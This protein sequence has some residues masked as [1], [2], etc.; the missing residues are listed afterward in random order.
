MFGPIP[1]KDV[2]KS[3]GQNANTGAVVCMHVGSTAAIASRCCTYTT[4]HTCAL[5]CFLF[6]PFLFFGLGQVR[7]VRFNL[8]LDNLPPEKHDPVGTGTC[9]SRVSL[10]FRFLVP[11]GLPCSLWLYISWKHPETS[12]CMDV[13]YEDVGRASSLISSRCQPGNFETLVCVGHDA[14]YT[15]LIEG[16]YVYPQLH[17]TESLMTCKA[18]R[19][20]SI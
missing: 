17:V 9:L 2:K 3:H 1:M 20:R 15:S 6:F 18:P 10:R 14:F 5:S 7:G 16:P 4:I 19:G 11:G 8:S 12:L 13:L